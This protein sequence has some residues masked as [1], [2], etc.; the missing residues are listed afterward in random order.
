MALISWN[1]AMTPPL[2]LLAKPPQPEQTVFGTDHKHIANLDLDASRDTAVQSLKDQ[3]FP[4]SRAQGQTVTPGGGK[5]NEEEAAEDSADFNAKD[6]QGRLERLSARLNTNLQ[7][8]KSTL[9]STEEPVDFRPHIL[10][11]KHDA[12]PMALVNRK[13][14]GSLDFK[15]V[16]N[17]QDIAWLAAVNYAKRSVFIQTPT[18]TAPP[19]VGACLDAAR[20]GVVVTIYADLGCALLPLLLLD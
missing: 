14:R 1:N 13:P 3:Q 9:P 15:D 11:A 19:I 18:F 7:H 20:R 6:R 16:N 2:P 12:F 5:S 8:T 4:A 17:P 10:H